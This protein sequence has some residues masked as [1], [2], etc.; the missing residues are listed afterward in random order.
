MHFLLGLNNWYQNELLMVSNKERIEN[1][2]IGLRS[3]QDTV[4]RLEV[5]MVDKLL[6]IEENLQCLTDTI[7]SSQ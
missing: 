3:L 5:G 2:K 6:L 4:S 7:M 1:L